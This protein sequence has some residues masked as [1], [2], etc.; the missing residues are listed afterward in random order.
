MKSV[1]SMI[2]SSIPCA[3]D[4]TYDSDEEAYVFSAGKRY[5]YLYDYESSHCVEAHFS[6]GR[7]LVFGYANSYLSVL[8]IK[9]FLDSYVEDMMPILYSACDVFEDVCIKFD[10]EPLFSHDAPFEY[11]FIIDGEEVAFMANVKD[12]RNVMFHCLSKSMDSFVVP[13]Y[14]KLDKA[15]FEEWVLSAL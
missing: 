14:E 11:R 15:R 4:C 10:I 8:M 6:N 7:N 2:N 12:P 9:F 5:V 1:I 3:F 13:V